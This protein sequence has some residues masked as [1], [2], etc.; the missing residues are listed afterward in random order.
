MMGKSKNSSSRAIR[1][2]LNLAVGVLTIGIAVIFYA[3]VAYG[4]KEAGSYSYDFA[5]QL[6]GDVSVEAAPGHDVKVTIMKG[7]SS[8][9]IASKLEDAK[10]VTNRYSFYLKLKLKEYDIMPGTFIL[11]TSMS[12]DDVLAVITDYGQSIDAETTVEDT[13]QTP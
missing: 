5:Y 12:Y 11:N 10:V 8:M 1:V 13:E 7:E 6:F 4:I 2:L 3:V 9:N